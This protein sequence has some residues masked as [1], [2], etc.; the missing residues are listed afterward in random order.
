MSR[1]A[2]D[3]LSNGIKISVIRSPIGFGFILIYLTM[4]IEVTAASIATPP[5]SPPWITPG[6]LP[7]CYEPLDEPVPLEAQPA[8]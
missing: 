2:L 4:L 8:A 5:P 6:R 3:L 1:P 7:A